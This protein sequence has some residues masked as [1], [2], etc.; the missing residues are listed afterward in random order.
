MELLLMAQIKNYLWYPWFS[1]QE[2]HTNIILIQLPPNNNFVSI[3][4]FAY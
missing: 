4:A 3:D 2:Q 1:L